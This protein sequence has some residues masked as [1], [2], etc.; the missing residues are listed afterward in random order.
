MTR[1]I[2]IRSGPTGWQ[3]W[4]N[5]AGEWWSLPFHIATAGQSVARQFVAD[6]HGVQPRQVCIDP[7]VT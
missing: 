3:R 5:F 4:D 7:A 1:R 6:L 2:A